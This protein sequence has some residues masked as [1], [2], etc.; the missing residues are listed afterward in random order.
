MP[1]KIKN[2]EL[3][4]RK[5]MRLPLSLI[6]AIENIAKIEDKSF[7]FTVVWLLKEGLKVYNDS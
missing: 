1:H 3:T 5:T 4:Q 7:T 6:G 2:N